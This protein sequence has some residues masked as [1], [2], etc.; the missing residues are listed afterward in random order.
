VTALLVANPV[1]AARV[2]GVLALEP[3]LY[4]LGPAGAF[5]VARLSAGGAAAVL[6][7]AL[8][9]WAIAP[10]AAAAVRFSLPLRRIRRGEQDKMVGNTARD[11]RTRPG[12]C[13]R[14]GG[15]VV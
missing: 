8:I 10:V 3:D 4:L 6:L 1:D 7:S 5:L 13:L 2:L 12:D 14:V 9:A 15:R 11:Q